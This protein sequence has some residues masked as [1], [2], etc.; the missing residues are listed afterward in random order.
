[1]TNKVSPIKPGDIAKVKKT[2]FPDKVFEAFNELIVAHF[3]NG[4]STIKQ[5]DIVEL[6]VKKGLERNQIFNNHWLDVEEV[7]RD[8]GWKV[9]YDKPAHCESYPATF[10]FKI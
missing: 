10:T 8:E 1:M 5:D 4:L 6:M 7:Y 2:I 3:S 9:E